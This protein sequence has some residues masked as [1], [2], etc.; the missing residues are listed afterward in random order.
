[1]TAPQPGRS[2][3]ICVSLAI[4]TAGCA[5]GGI[6]PPAPR[7]PDTPRPRQ[8]PAVHTLAPEP[9]VGTD[10][11]PTGAAVPTEVPEVSQEPGAE[12]PAEVSVA[13]WNPP[14]Y[15][16][17]LAL[18]PQ[19]HFY[20]R[21]PIPSG[22]STWLHPLYRYG[23]THF[24]EEPTHTGIDIVADMGTPVL[25][26]GE[27]EVVWVGYGLYRGIEDET[28]PYGLSVAIEHDFGYEGQRLFSVYGHL[29]HT[30][31]HHGQP[32]RAGEVVG[33]VGNT[34]HA[35]GPHL[36]FEV[37]LGENRYFHTRNPELWIVPPEGW[38]VLVGR[39]LDSVGR[40]LVEYPIFVRNLETDRV[41]E[42]YTYAKEAIHPDG[43]FD[44]NVVV[45]DLPAGPY[46]VKINYLGKAYTAQLYLY[47]GQTNLV[48]FRGRGGFALEAED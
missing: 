42:I 37:R 40:P 25:A 15:D 33:T 13:N 46:E 9:L 28:D 26:V 36:H 47:P 30:Q 10:V 20:F 31:V 1:M 7:V 35:S 5:G 34:G 32:V 17:P 21:R 14:P 4:L 11:A 23:N 12:S 38:G 18:R 19:D 39:I 45:G 29:N 8:N 43:V 16:A 3:T 2:L 22:E 24:G 27:G 6:Q 41:I 48:T 44:E